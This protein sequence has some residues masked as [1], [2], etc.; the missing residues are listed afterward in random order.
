RLNAR[1]QAERAARLVRLGI[2]TASVGGVLFGAALLL[3]GPA[4]F[5]LIYGTHHAGQAQL[6]FCGVALP[7]IWALIAVARVDLRARQNVRLIFFGYA[8]GGLLVGVPILPLV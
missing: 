6:V 8:V 3:V 4:A 2:V 7:M 5:T 1:G